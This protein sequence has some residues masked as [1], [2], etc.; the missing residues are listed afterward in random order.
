MNRR[1]TIFIQLTGQ[2]DG[3][4]ATPAFL[5][6]TCAGTQTLNVPTRVSLVFN[7]Y[8]LFCGPHYFTKVHSTGEAVVLRGRGVI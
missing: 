5:L 1:A 4:S 8:F 6:A 7:K 3:G 2:S